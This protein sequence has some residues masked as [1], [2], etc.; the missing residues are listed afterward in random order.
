MWADGVDIL[1]KDTNS[2]HLIHKEIMFKLLIVWVYCLFS[3]IWDIWSGS[4][5]WYNSTGAQRVSVMTPQ[6]SE[7]KNILFNIRRFKSDRRFKW[8]SVC[9][10]VIFPGA[11]RTTRNLHAHL[12]EAPLTK[13]HYQVTGYGIV[14]RSQTWSCAIKRWLFSPYCSVQSTNDLL[15]DFWVKFVSCW[16]YF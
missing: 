6:S 14:S 8:F 13:K 9:D 3:S 4:S 7:M 5:W 11:F 16:S 12:H 10:D 15:D 1:F 2:V